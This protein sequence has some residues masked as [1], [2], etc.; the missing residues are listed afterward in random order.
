VQREAPRPIAWVILL[1]LAPAGGCVTSSQG[2]D[3]RRDILALQAQFDE[4]RAEKEE[5]KATLKRASKEIGSLE[6]TNAEA[7]ELLRRNSADF[8]VQV[9][10]LRTEVQR[11]RGASEE[12]KHEIEVLKQR[13]TAIDAAKAKKAASAAEMP[14]DK[15]GLYTYGYERFNGGDMKEARR[16]FD[17][18]ARMFPNDKRADNAIYFAGEALFN[19]RRYADAVVTL[20]Q[21]LTAYRGGDKEDDAIFKM[22]ESFGAMG[23]CIESHVFFEDLVKTHPKSSHVATA[24]KKLRKRCR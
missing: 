13:Q 9:D 21:I 16:A 2:R 20:Q 11:L 18:Y 1:V 10:S 23:K 5:L 17:E 24:K 22:G 14:S 4:L 12:L 6:R 15:D 8:G 7:T 3:M 19:E